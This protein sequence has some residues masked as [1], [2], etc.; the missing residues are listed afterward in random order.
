MQIGGGHDAPGFAIP[1]SGESQISVAITFYEGSLHSTS[2]N[3]GTG[4]REDRNAR[5]GVGVDR[6]GGAGVSTA[7]QALPSQ[8][9]RNPPRPSPTA[10]ISLAELPAMMPRESG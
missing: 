2:N 5:E 10:Q 4:G 1:M 9:S 8:C 6:P 3:P 7:L